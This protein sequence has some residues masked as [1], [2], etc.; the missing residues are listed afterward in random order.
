[1][2]KRAFLKSLSFAAVTLPF[3]LSAL[4]KTLSEYADIHPQDLANDE[5]FWE[6]IRS[7]YKLKSEYINLENGYY[8]FMPQETLEHFI[9][10]VREVNL[11]GSWYMRTVQWENKKKSASMLA[12]MAGCNADELI[13]TRNTTESLDLVI[14]GLDWQQGDE[15]VMAEQDYG[16]M[17]DQFKLMEKRYGIKAKSSQK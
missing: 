17:L 5:A 9:Q 14:A 3:S 7:G 12:D 13:I 8:C 4:E 1:M 11:Q 10:H 16:S 2:N 6:K 15:A